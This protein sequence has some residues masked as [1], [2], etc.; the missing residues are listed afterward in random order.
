MPEPLPEEFRI[1]LAETASRRGAFGST[2]V[3]VSETAIHQRHRD[4]AGRARRARKGPWRSRSRRRPAVAATAASGSRRPAPASTSSIVCRTPAI[5]PTL[6]LA[7]GV[8]VA[9]GITRATG[10]PVAIKWPNDIVVPDRNAPGQA[11]QARRHPG[12]RRGRPGRRPVRRPGVRH[13]RPACRL[14]GRDRRA[15]DVD[16]ARARP[17][18]RGRA[19]ARGDAGRVERAGGC[20]LPRRK[21][22]GSW[23]AGARC[24]RR[25]PAPAWNGPPT[26]RIHQGV[27]SGIDDEARCWSGPRSGWNV[28][29]RAKWCGDDGAPELGVGT[30]IRGSAGPQ[31]QPIGMRRDKDI[32]VSF[33]VPS[34][35]PL[36]RF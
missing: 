25:P 32:E 29:L 11:P 4:G 30:R 36:L 13:Q 22:P 33:S 23:T 9:D 12:R 27:T 15:R 8:A 10:L 28:S 14:P 35:T 18:G 5:L 34:L 19:G 2:V 21:R 17:A 6:T 26:A 24:R 20:A 7:G 16:R 31:R 1:A 3:F